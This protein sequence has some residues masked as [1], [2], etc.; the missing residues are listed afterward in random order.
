M[1]KNELR[2]VTIHPNGL[3]SYKGF[4][5]GF[6]EEVGYSEDQRSYV[7]KLAMVER[8]DNHKIVLVSPELL[9]FTDHP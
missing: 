5:H 3:A 2:S 4:F 1:E 8:A 6:T 7:Y 9:Q